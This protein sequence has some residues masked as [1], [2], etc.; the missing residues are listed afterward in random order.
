MLCLW[1]DSKQEQGRGVRG[2]RQRGRR[3][4]GQGRRTAPKND[5]RKKWTK[6]ESPDDFVPKNIPF[7]DN[8]CL[9][10]RIKNDAGPMDFFNLYI[11]PEII[12]LLVIET[13]RYAQQYI[14][15]KGDT[16]KEHS[17]VQDWKETDTHE[18]RTFLGV[19]LLMGIV[20][21]PRMTMYWSTDEI[22]S[23]PIFSQVISRNRFFLLLKFLQFSNNDDPFFDPKDENR[24]RLHKVR[25]LI[26]M[27]RERCKKIYYPGKN[28]SVDESLVLFK[29]RLAF[30]QYIKTK[31]ARFGI[32]LYELCSSNGVTLDFFVYCGKGFFDDENDEEHKDFSVTE[33]IP[34]KLMSDY[35]GN[36]HCVFVDNFYILLLNLLSTCWT[37]IPICV[38]QLIVKGAIIPRKLCQKSLRK[39]RL[40]FISQGNSL[41]ASIEL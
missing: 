3:Q 34:A 27:I 32:K 10:V 18:M 17:N 24:D 2:R 40:F 37:I 1:E 11:T 25:P 28:L 7:I 33:K 9:K 20:Y 29:G 30:K 16:I 31:R 36:G 35:Y 15:L 5:E 8:E 19:L 6:V 41:H 13:N 14:A 23:T 38:E 22:F 26:N 4:A 12:E 21:K 39:E